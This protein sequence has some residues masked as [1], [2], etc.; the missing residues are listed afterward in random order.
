M[1]TL[2]MNRKEVRMLSGLL[3]KLI[4]RE[5][6]A[7]LHLTQTNIL[8]KRNSKEITKQRLSHCPALMEYLD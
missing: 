6:S 3:I 7:Y 1:Y 4:E 2:W 8:M 5:R